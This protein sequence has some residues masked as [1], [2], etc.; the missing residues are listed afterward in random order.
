MLAWEA[1]GERGCD[2]KNAAFMVGEGDADVICSKCKGRV[3]PIWA[4]KQLALYDRRY[5]DNRE[6][7]LEEQKRLAERSKTKCENCGKMTRISRR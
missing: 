1:P 5:A 2:H 7:Y 3:D 6:R 4:L